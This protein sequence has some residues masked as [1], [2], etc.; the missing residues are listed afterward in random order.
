MVLRDRSNN[1]YFVL[2]ACNSNVSC[3]DRTSL[4]HR[5]W[6]LSEGKR[7]VEKHPCLSRLGPLRARLSIEWQRA[8]TGG[9]LGQLF[10]MLPDLDEAVASEPA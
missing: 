8:L 9:R 6:R 7:V 1:L 3:D 2:I 10:K 5:R 4:D